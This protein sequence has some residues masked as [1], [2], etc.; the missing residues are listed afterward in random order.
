MEKKTLSYF[1]F[2][3]K[4]SDKFKDILTKKVYGIF[5][6]E[7]NKKVLVPKNS[8]QMKKNISHE[9]DEKVEDTNGNNCFLIYFK[10]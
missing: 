8:N 3:Q 4:S 9:F 2:N 7:N 10:I 1:S 6:N 5:L